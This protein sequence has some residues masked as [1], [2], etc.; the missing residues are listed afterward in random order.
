MHWKIRPATP[1]DISFIYATWLPSYYVD[2]SYFKTIRNRIYYTNYR[3]VIDTIL[4]S[5][6]IDVACKPDEDN[7]IFGYMVS[8]PETA[9]YVFIKEPFRGFKIARALYSNRFK[10]DEIVVITHQTKHLRPLIENKDN[11]VFNPFKL[12]KGM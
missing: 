9:H 12:Y 6:R 5:A 3:E 11:I 7:V 8:E 2:T 10:P 1:D 4:L